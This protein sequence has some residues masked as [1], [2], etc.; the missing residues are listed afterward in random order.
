MRAL[1]TAVITDI[2]SM[3]LATVRLDGLERPVPRRHAL[4]IAATKV[5]VLAVHACATH[6]IPDATA[7][8]SNARTHALVLELAST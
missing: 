6:N 8:F 4:Q 2:A 1:A 3:E 5:I 7:R